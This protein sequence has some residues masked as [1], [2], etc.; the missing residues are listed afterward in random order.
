MIKRKDKYNIIIEK[1]NSANRLLEELNKREQNKYMKGRDSS[2]TGD[3]SFTETKTYNE[4]AK[5]LIYGYDKPIEKIK[6]DF[7]IARYKDKISFENNVYGF[8][9]N[10]PNSIM[11]LPHS[12]VYT[13]RK[14]K[15]SKILELIYSP[16][17]NA[18]VSK[19]KFIENGIKMLNVISILEANG[20]SVKLTCALYCGKN[21]SNE[22]A[23]STLSV[24]DYGQRLNL[25]KIAF[26]TVHPSFLRRIGFKWLETSP[27]ITTD[28]FAFGYGQALSMGSYEYELLTE[29]LSKEERLILLPNIIDKSEEEILEMLVV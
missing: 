15:K 27:D 3:Y 6:G 28:G 1:F 22:I 7:K 25:L 23:L 14:P 26:P 17:A 18:G 9:P 20:I 13:S 16:D 19:E 10:V 2:R 8:V 12:M 24:K 11:G 4:A 29:F 21:N 5:L